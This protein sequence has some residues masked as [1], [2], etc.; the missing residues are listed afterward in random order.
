MSD[1][2]KK[3]ERSGPRAVSP[4]RLA[5]ADITTALKNA[6]VAREL[7]A[8]T[9]SRLPYPCDAAAE[10]IVLTGMIWGAVREPLPPDLFF[11]VLH[12]EIAVAIEATGP[13]RDANALCEAVCKRTRNMSQSVID[14]IFELCAVEYSARE[15]ERA[16]M[17]VSMLAEARVLIEELER[18]VRLLRAD[19]TSVEDVRPILARLGRDS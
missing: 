1:A 5:S 7:A 17:R 12:Q 6:L 13:T 2:A 18:V 9:N 19:A 16:C 4:G 8:L 3:Y 14:L 10:E 15:F 11:F